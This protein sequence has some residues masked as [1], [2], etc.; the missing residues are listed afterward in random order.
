VTTQNEVV[1]MVTITNFGGVWTP[2]GLHRG[3]LAARIS[4]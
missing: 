2:F 4:A 3:T 1:T